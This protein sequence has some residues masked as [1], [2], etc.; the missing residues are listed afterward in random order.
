[1]VTEESTYADPKDPRVV[2]AAR[3]YFDL[4]DRGQAVDREQFIA[5][6]PHIAQ[7]LRTAIA[8]EDERRR[9]QATEP[10]RHLTG[11]STGAFARHGDTLPPPSRSGFGPA[12]STLSPGAQLGRYTIV[13]VLGRGAMGTVYLA[14][15]TQLDRQVAL[16]TP[17]FDQD[18]DLLERFHREARAA[19]QYLSDL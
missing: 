5:Q 15:D 10:P 14:M 6:K 3:E 8:D 18:P 4:L 9:L 19:P 2:A 7:L 11:G 13:R 12:A 16:K 17:Q 1:M